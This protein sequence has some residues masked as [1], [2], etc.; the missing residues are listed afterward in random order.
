MPRQPRPRRSQH[1]DD[2]FGRD[3]LLQ[4]ARRWSDARV[5]FDRTTDVSGRCPNCDGLVRRLGPGVLC[6]TCG[7]LWVVRELLDQETGVTGAA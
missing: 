4:R 2:R 7:R 1:S 3:T 5:T 6:S